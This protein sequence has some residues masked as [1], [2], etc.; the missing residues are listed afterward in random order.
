M[1]RLQP[2][3]PGFGDTLPPPPGVLLPPEYHRNTPITDT[4]T[5]ETI[6]KELPSL[7]GAYW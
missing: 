3:R 7:V 4:D 6:A 1:S 2:Y 5:D